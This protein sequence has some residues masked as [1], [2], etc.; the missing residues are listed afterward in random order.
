MASAAISIAS[1]RAFALTSTSYLCCLPIFLGLAC[2]F[3]VMKTLTDAQCAVDSTTR[4]RQDRMIYGE[5]HLEIQRTL[6]KIID[7]D[8]NPHV[9][10]WEA[11]GIFPA[12]PV[13]KKLG[14]A[15]LLGVTKPATY[16]GMG[17]DYTFGTA[18]AE[19]LG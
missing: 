11:E 6:R 2:V 3:D 10:A 14:K 7:H 12:H 13:F 19:A 18:M 9:D 1:S 17:L 16:G 4:L 15:G 8:I 5:E